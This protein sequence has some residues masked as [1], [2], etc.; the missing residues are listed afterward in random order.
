MLYNCAPHYEE[1]PGWKVDISGI[2]EFDKLPK[3]AQ[4]YVEFIAE[5]TGVPVRWVSVGPER[6]QLITVP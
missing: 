5:H 4:Q 3:E 1:F 6:S 2:T